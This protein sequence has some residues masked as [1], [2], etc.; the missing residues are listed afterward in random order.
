MY[1]RH[2]CSAW[3][4]ITPRA[5][6]CQGIFGNFFGKRKKTA[7][8]Q[9]V[10]QKE[11][12][13]FVHF[14]VYEAA[15]AAS[16]IEVCKT[17]TNFPEGKF[18]S[19]LPYFLYFTKSRK[20]KSPQ[21]G[22]RLPQATQKGGAAADNSAKRKDL[23]Q[24][25]QKMMPPMAAK[26]FNFV[27]GSCCLCVLLRGLQNLELPERETDW[28]FLRRAKSTAKTR[29]DVQKVAGGKFLCVG[30]RRNRENCERT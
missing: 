4:Y 19:F 28:Y 7:Q 22:D 10:A 18:Q 26:G 1:L 29:S 14:A 21:G 23:L 25:Q 12:L 30:D 16:R 5:W 17:S 11:G 9:K 20:K 15:A 27:S 8:Y 6:I 3:Y 24:Q 2:L 13:P